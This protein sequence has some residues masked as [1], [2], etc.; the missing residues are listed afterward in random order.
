MRYLI[1]GVTEARGPDG[2]SLPLGGPRLR[3]LL[4]ALA[5]R[6]GR[7]VPV[8]ELVADVWG[9][10]GEPPRDAPAALQALVSRLRRA[11]GGKHTV[12]A[13]ATG[14]RLD[15]TEDDIDLH[16]FRR[17]ARQG[18]AELATDPAAA[19]RTLGR[20][21]ALWRGP[22][23]A[24]LPDAD[25]EPAVRNAHALREAAVRDRIDAEL[26]SGTEPAA[27][28]PELEQLLVAHPYDEPL[29]AR[30]LRALRAAGRQ[31]DALLAYE[32]F[33]RALA[34]RLGTDPGPELRSLHAELLAPAP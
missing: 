30:H 17:L 8:T 7:T 33:R 9:G 23:L 19:A 26:R 6:G 14:Y 5:L 28:L 11:L 16:V 15:A 25:T 22:A 31:A 34:D 4:A 10:G 20:A 24:D 2:G 3:A 21:L 1:L 13:G 29:R 32:E 18:A 12:L 27:L